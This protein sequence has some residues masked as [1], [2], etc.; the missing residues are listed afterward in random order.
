[1]TVCVCDYCLNYEIDVTLID[2]RLMN[3]EVDVTSKYILEEF[4]YSFSFKMRGP[5]MELVLIKSSI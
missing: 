2:V 3:Y 4:L 5:W 1:M